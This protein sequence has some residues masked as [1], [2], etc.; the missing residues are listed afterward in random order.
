MWFF[1]CVK[2][3]THHWVINV[4]GARTYVVL[5]IMCQH[6]R[7]CPAAGERHYHYPLRQHF[8]Q[9]R[10]SLRSPLHSTVSLLSEYLSSGP[11][12]GSFTCPCSAS[13]GAMSGAISFLSFLPWTPILHTP[14]TPFSLLLEI[15]SLAVCWV[16]RSNQLARTM[17]SI[18]DKGPLSCLCWRYPHANPRI[19]AHAVAL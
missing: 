8:W 9:G 13:W 17:I 7:K 6:E 4:M 10:P 19:S 16:D 3:P 14:S 1:F 2:S 11:S 15:C 12:H 18:T 5:V